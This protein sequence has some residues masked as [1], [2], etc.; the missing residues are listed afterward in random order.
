MVTADRVLTDAQL[1]RFLKHLR[2]E[3]DRS[4]TVLQAK[5][6][7]NRRDT[8]IVIDYYLFSLICNTGLRISE[9][10]NLKTTDIH[11][12]FLVIR[13]E[14]SK[15]GKRGTVY[16]GHKTRKLLDE[17]IL[18]KA[19][20]LKIDTSDFLFSKGSKLL[21]RSYMHGR[22]KMWMKQIGYAPELSIHCLRH[23]YATQCLDKGLSLQF[24][25]ENLR[26]SNIGIT[27]RYLH[28]T[29]ENRDKVKDLF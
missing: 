19:I 12:D 4:I 6:K 2:S 11:D 14:V 9:A 1:T 29:K 25:R 24:V 15:N 8:R 13:P 23:T 22:F 16:F 5:I 3:K 7:P 28:L 20:T 27:S 18:I 10:L 26:H 17:F 21:S